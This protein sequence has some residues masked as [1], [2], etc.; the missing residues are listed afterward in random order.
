MGQAEGLG[1]D[2]GEWKGRGMKKM[3]KKSWPSQNC[4]D[5]DPGCKHCN[6]QCDRRAKVILRR[7]DM[8]DV[9]GTYF[10]RVCAEDAMETGLFR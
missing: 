1:T 3:K 5:S 7:I 9:T 4:E 8:E 2:S 10:C 6:G